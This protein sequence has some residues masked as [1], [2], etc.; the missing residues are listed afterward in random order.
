[1][2]SLYF[3]FLCVS[4]G[5]LESILRTNK[6]LSVQKNENTACFMYLPVF[7][8]FLL[9]IT[10]RLR[11]KLIKRTDFVTQKRFPVSF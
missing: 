1:M 4:Q 11:R 10:F 5:K 6:V 9:A 8:N 7:V 3:F 2:Q